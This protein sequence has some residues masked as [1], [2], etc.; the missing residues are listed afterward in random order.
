MLGARVLRRLRCGCVQ[1]RRVLGGIV[2]KPHHERSFMEIAF[3]VVRK[4]EQRNG[5]G[6]K[7][8]APRRAA[9]PPTPD[10]TPSRPR[11]RRLIQRLKEYAIRE[12]GVLHLLTYADDSAI[13]FF[14]RLGFEPDDR[15]GGAR[16][17]PRATRTP[18]A[19]LPPAPR[20][21]LTAPSVGGA[22]MHINRFHWGIS[23]Y[24]GS[25]LRQCAL[26][27]DGKTLYAPKFPR[28]VPPEGRRL[29][30]PA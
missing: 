29:A 20:A 7:C 13:G 19:A 23:H 14:E 17:R 25:Q 2:L 30:A 6:S 10:P 1:V 24:I 15:S 27:P 26:D 18:R 21:P 16:R 5:V 11:T 12:L 28:V 3:C 22:G 8:A 4:E 9:P